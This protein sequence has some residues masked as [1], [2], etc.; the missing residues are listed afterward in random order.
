[1]ELIWCALFS[2]RLSAQDLLTVKKV[3]E[4]VYDKVYGDKGEDA[5]KEGRGSNMEITCADQV[6]L[7]CQH[8]CSCPCSLTV[9]VQVL[10]IELD[11]R[12]VKHTVWRS[13]GDMKLFYK[14]CAESAGEEKEAADSGS[15]KE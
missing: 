7:V 10:D 12:S 6:C 5:G 1:M 14:E 15:V 4:Y 11:L 8:A 3:Q 13:G 2:D 9:H